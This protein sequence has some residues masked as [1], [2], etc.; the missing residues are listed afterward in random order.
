MISDLKSVARDRVSCGSPSPLLGDACGLE[1][2]AVQSTGSDMG[3][4]GDFVDI[5]ALGGGR[6]ALVV[7]DIC[8]R[9]LPAYRQV[10]HIQPRLRRLL[11]ECD[12]PGRALSELN[13]Q[14]DADQRRGL[15][16]DGQ[17]VCISVVVT[18]PL[19]DT[20]STAVA[21]TEAPVLLVSGI[22]P[23]FIPAGGPLVGVDSGAGYETVTTSFFRHDL[24]N[25]FSD[26]MTD[27]RRDGQFLELGGFVHIVQQVVSE[28]ESPLSVAQIAARI[29][30]RVRVFAGGRIHDD[31][32]LL[33]ARRTS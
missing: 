3:V 6:V 31:A 5:I 10:L 4:G 13:S 14:F 11:M 2:A 22:E 32:S 17:F 16:P 28:S 12:C 24:L 9:G 7:G 26:G 27:A 8:G 29:F 23:R 30:E 15:I 18:D 33:I 19:N 25:L 1:V 20:I 21:G